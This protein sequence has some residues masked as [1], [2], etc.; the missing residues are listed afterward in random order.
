MKPELKSSLILFVT[1]A[2]GV[3]LGL[4]VQ[5]TLAR[6]RTRKVAELRG[7][8]GFVAHMEA[9]IQPRDDA[10]RRAIGPILEETGQRNGVII[11]SA[12][13]E[14]RAALDSMRAR[15][16]PLLDQEQRNRLGRIGRL[17]D[18]FQPPP[19]DGRGPPPPDGRGPPPRDG[20]GPPPR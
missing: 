1:L 17:P 15:L 20:R 2:F 18:P 8:P 4:A 10:Q 6:E 14:L 19:R 12:N 3:L 7:P 5:G 16:A 13:A 11:G 9:V